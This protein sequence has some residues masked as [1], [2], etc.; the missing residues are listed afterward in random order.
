M[1]ETP[2]ARALLTID[3]DSHLFT[4]ILPTLLREAAEWG[5]VDATVTIHGHGDQE[6]TGF[7]REYDERDPEDVY[8]TLDVKGHTEVL[9]LAQI[10]TLHLH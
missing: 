7:V 1:P 3:S 5:G 9:R 4:T 10:A 6:W 8:V 2:P